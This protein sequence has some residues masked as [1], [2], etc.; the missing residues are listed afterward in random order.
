LIDTI[1]GLSSFVLGQ[2]CGINLYTDGNNWNIVNYINNYIS[3]TATT[4][5]I[6]GNIYV[7]GDTYS[8]N[9]IL[10]KTSGSG[11]MLDTTSPTYGWKDI[12]GFQLPDIIG[13]NSPTLATFIGGSVRRFAYSA[14]DKMDCE[15]HIPHD[16]APGTNLYS[17]VHWSHNG[18]SITGNFVGTIAFTYCKGHG[19]TAH[20][21]NTEKTATITYATVNTGSTPRY[22]H[23]ID[24]IMITSGTTD[25][26]H[27]DVALIEPDGV[28]ALN[29]TQTTIP[30]I[31]GGSPNEPFVFFIDLHYQ[32]TQ[33]ATKQKT[34]NFYV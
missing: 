30:T 26:S 29:Y 3:L 28:I 33:T 11:I 22:G 20:T 16:Y 6:N 27:L 34:P 10:D 25:A 19:Q 12:I 13:V 23:R 8:K 18:T 4:A 31:G 24:E 21:F 14:A 5:K 32:S 1:D 15:F 2:Y 7:T 9:L 17:H